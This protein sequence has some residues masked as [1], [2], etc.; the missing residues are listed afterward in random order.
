M[1]K[2][3][4]W[5]T[6]H[7]YYEGCSLDILKERGIEV[8]TDDNPDYVLS[9]IEELEK[10][11]HIVCTM[12]LAVGDKFDLK[13][14]EAGTKTGF[15]LF[16]DIVDKIKKTKLILRV[17]S[18][19]EIYQDEYDFCKEKGITVVNDGDSKY[20]TIYQL[21]TGK[22]FYEDDSAQSDVDSKVQH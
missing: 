12:F 22:R 20:D 8:V 11:S 16:H 4:L 1:D 17:A 7:K 18:S 10:F 13:R 19:I 2:K 6:N 15:I 21:I 5:L 14:C 9:H 3:V